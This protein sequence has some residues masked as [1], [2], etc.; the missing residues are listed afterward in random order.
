M[1]GSWGFAMVD[2]PRRRLGKDQAENIAKLF[3]K[4]GYSVHQSTDRVVL[5]RDHKF[6]AAFYWEKNDGW[7]LD[8]RHPTVASEDDLITASMSIAVTESTVTATHAAW[9][10]FQASKSDKAWQRYLGLMAAHFQSLLQ[11]PAEDAEGEEET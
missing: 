9:K 6:V 2:T 7:R 3:T 11:P 8:L 5:W 10:K 4:K 1:T